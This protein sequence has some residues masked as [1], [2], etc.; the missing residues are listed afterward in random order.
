MLFNISE[1]KP[2]HDFLVCIDSDGCAFDTMEIKHKECF[3]PTTIEYWDLQPVSSMAREACE[4]VNLY[5]KTRGIN[6]FPAL[7]RTLD[8]LCERKEVQQRGF[9]PPAYDKFKTWVETTPAQTNDEVSK[10]LDEPQMQRVLDWSLEV[11]RRIAKMVHGIPPFP[12][13][14]ESLKKLSDKA[15]IVIVSATPREALQ[16]EWTEHGIDRYV[17]LLGSQENGSKAEIIAAIKDNYEPACALMIGD[18]P[19]DQNAAEKNGIL[20]YPIRPLDEV[21]SWE[22]FCNAGIDQFLNRK[23]KGE[24]MEENIRRFSECL[25]EDPPWL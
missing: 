25:P 19:G 23:Y 5:S 12:F 21:A 20:Y 11:N 3:C 4:F 8:L 2:K 22:E 1:F 9:K 10:H 15:D 13:V 14:R 18:A 7:I 6:R 16:K 17:S 24:A